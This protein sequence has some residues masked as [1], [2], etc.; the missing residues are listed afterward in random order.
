MLILQTHQAVSRAI[1]VL[2]RTSGKMYPSKNKILQAY[3]A[4]EALTNHA[5]TY[6]CVSCGHNPASVVMDLHKKGVFSMPGKLI[7][8]PIYPS[9]YSVCNFW[10]L[11]GAPSF[12]F[13]LQ[14][15]DIEE[16]PEGFDG[17]INVEDFWEMV[18]MEMIARGLVPSEYEGN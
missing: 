4:F 7:S 8:V 15:S 18:C 2:E 12:I 17:N 6:S 11:F 3:L 13:F 9:C 1:E 10:P 14:V 16:P 5:Y